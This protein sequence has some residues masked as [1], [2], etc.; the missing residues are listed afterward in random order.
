V[1]PLPTQTLPAAPRC[2]LAD[3]L[4]GPMSPVAANSPLMTTKRVGTGLCFVI[5]PIVFVFAFAVHPDLLSPRL[6]EPSELILR[7]HG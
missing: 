1:S 4:V 6:L 2:P 5:F 3:V 7:A